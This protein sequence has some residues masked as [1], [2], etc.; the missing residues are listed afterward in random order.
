MLP[1]TL[2]QLLLVTRCN[3]SKFLLHW[4]NRALLILKITVISRDLS[5]VCFL[6][7]LTVPF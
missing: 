1:V 3:V 4:S 6:E 2:L 7:K 5:V